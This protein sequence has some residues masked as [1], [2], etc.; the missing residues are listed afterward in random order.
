VRQIDQHG[1]EYLTWW[2]GT[3]QA[4][5]EGVVPRLLRLM[6]EV[7]ARERITF[8][9]EPDLLSGPPLDILVWLDEGGPV[10]TIRLYS[11]E[12]PNGMYSIV[13]IG[14]D[15]DDLPTYRRQDQP[16]DDSGQPVTP[17]FE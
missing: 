4:L 15:A 14:V 17:T 13:R 2:L 10:V 12:D 5:V 1:D 9:N 8:Y 11:D 16:P 3:D 6:R 7:E